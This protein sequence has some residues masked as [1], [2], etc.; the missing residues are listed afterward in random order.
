MSKEN[1]E[2]IRQDGERA[3]RIQEHMA[4]TEKMLDKPLATSVTR[5]SKVANLLVANTDLPAST[6]DDILEDAIFTSRGRNNHRGVESVELRHNADDT[7]DLHARFAPK[8]KT[9]E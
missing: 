6:G 7:I 1:D 4:F 5:V 9:D 8:P 3:S 2:T